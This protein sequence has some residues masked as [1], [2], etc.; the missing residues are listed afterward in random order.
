MASKVSTGNSPS[1]MRYVSSRIGHKERCL[2]AEASCSPGP[3]LQV[4][5]V[6]QSTKQRMT[7]DHIDYWPVVDGTS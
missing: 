6:N 7:V 5:M 4:I 2:E 3:N 1:A